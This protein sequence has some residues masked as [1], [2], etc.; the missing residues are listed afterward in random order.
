M[1]KTFAF[2]ALLLMLNF[3]AKAQS[4]AVNTDGSAADVS[5]LLDI[6]STSKGLL[7]PRM[8]LA[9]KN[10]VS[11]PATGLLVYQT[12]GTKGL[13]VNNGTPAAPNWQLVTASSNAWGLTGNAGTIDGTNFIGTTDNIPFTIKVN[14]QKAGRIDHLLGNSFF[15]YQSGNNNSTGVSNTANGHMAFFANTTGS[16]NTA[17][18]DSAL[19]HNTTGTYNTANGY[20]ALNANTTG[21]YNIANGPL[22]LYRNTN[23]VYNIATGLNA[24]GNNTS[25]NANNAYGF[26]SLLM[27][28]IGGDNAAF[29]SYTLLANT[30]G[31][32]NTANGNYALEFNTTGIGNSA[33]GSY[34]LTNNSVGGS[35]T[36]IGYFSLATNTVGSNGTAI[37]TYAMENFYGSST[38]FINYN[39]AVGYQ[40]LMGSAISTNNT[41]N[42]NTALGYQTL[43][44]NTTGSHN[45][46]VGYLALYS[47]SYGDLNTAIGDSALFNNTGGWRNI[48]IGF[49]ALNSNIGGFENTASGAYALYQNTNGSYNTATGA[50]ALAYN[51]TGDNNN[52][53]GFA[54]LDS[55]T[56]GRENSAYG[57]YSLFH[58]DFGNRNTAIGFN[59]LKL[60]ISGSDNIANGFNSLTYNTVGVGNTALGAASLFNNTF[61]NYNTAIGCVAGPAAGGYTNTTSIGYL[62]AAT[63]SN[64]MQFGNSAITDVYAGVSNNATLHSGYAIISRALNVDYQDQNGSANTYVIKFGGAGTG[65]GIGSNRTSA[66]NQWGLDFYTGAANRMCIGLNG[67]IGMGTTA[68]TS[69]LDVNGQITIDQ[70][71]FGGYAGLLVKGNSSVSNYP[72]IAFSTQ[73]TAANDIISAIIGGTITN[74]TAGSEAIDLSF[75]TSTSGQSG[76]AQRM[77]IKDNGNVGIGETAPIAPLNFTSAVLG[78][79]ISLWGNGA[80]HYGMGIQAFLM[81]LYTQDINGNIAFGYGSSG[82]FTETMR[83]KGNGNV[84]IGTSSPTA[85]LSV[86]GTANNSTGNWTVFSDERIKTIT[87]DFTDGLTVIKKIQPVK[88]R[89]NDNAPFKSD[90]EQIGIVAQDLEKIAPYMVSQKPYKE[91][92]DLREVNNQAYVFLLINAVKEQQVQIEAQ[93]KENDGQKQRIDDLEKI[94]KELSRK[95]NQ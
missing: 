34:T 23:G 8:T 85:M 71:N 6:K 9:Q 46:A 94:V 43:R 89:Y 76:L 58:N 26:Q 47:N 37:G 65:E 75:Y 59:A 83:I 20:N 48:A 92:N 24:L 81:Q 36:G 13:Y 14:N 32:G 87:D 54:S 79:R 93:K 50:G 72:N 49:N 41:G 30:T 53:Y 51:T 73:N 82:A 3:Y 31:G 80:T 21:T 84:G 88:F 61:G 38:P 40:S 90:E 15:G 74:N 11:L 25:G 19:Y 70:K 52:A 78:N 64:T 5:A 42:Y 86:N 62:A 68:P 44:S 69:K 16:G 45:N 18:G 12:D 95:A 7:I 39:V 57:S 55:N 35:N 2:I 1:K 27:N 63:A 22:A 60:N 28:T 66:V 91:F 33:V 29:G 10:V 4:L 56:T 77:V 67:N 17:T